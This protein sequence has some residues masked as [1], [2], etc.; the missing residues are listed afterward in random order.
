MLHFSLDVHTRNIDALV[1]L[2]IPADFPIL[3]RKLCTPSIEGAAA[4]G[5]RPALLLGAA[6]AL[7]AFG[8]AWG[9]QPLR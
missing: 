8:L 6:T 7:V 3:Q 9:S 2:L 1:A 5:A 4:R